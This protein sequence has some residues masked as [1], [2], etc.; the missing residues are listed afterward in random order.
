MGDCA[1]RRDLEAAK[2]RM[3]IFHSKLRMAV[4]ASLVPSCYL[5]R[6]MRWILGETPLNG[7]GGWDC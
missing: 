7:L 1:L 4:K 2:P 6:V 3:C 5:R